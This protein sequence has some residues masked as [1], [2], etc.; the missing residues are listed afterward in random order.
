MK[1]VKCEGCG[2]EV[3]EDNLDRYGD[4]SWCREDERAHNMCVGDLKEK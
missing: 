1:K 4:C 2:K 3:E